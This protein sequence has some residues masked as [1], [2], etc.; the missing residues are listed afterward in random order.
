VDPL[1]VLLALLLVVAGLSSMRLYILALFERRLFARVVAEITVRTVHAQNPF[2]VDESRSS[3]FNR[4]FDTAIIQKSVPSL[5]IGAFTIVL[6]GAV[7]LMVT[8]FYHPFFL[9]FNLILVLACLAIWLIWRRGRLPGR[10]GS[11]MPSTMPRSGWKVWAA[12]TASTSRPAT[13]TLRWT[14]PKR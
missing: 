11:A 10:S 13:S 8:S 6:Q 2:F 3:L 4:Y 9:A 12:P 14:A 5:V 7:G 1:G